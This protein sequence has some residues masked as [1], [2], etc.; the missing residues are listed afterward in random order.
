MLVPCGPYRGYG[1]PEFAGFTGTVRPVID[2]LSGDDA[3]VMPSSPPLLD[4]SAPPPTPA[5]PAA[6]PSPWLAAPVAPASWRLEGLLLDAVLVVCTV[7]IGWLAWWIIDW[8]SGRS[9]AKSILHT[10]V[11]RADNRELPGFGRMALREGLGKA[12]PAGAGLIGLSM[13]GDGGIAPFLVA[14]SVAWYAMSI[15]A[16]LLDDQR[17][18]LWDTFARTVVVLD[19]DVSRTVEARTQPT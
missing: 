15:V 13:L 14:A 4:A 7:V 6:E 12:L 11:V 2:G 5:P 17:R 19:A 9:P 16:A 3:V 10:R 18:T 1:D 8:D